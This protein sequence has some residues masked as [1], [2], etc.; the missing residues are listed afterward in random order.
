MANAAVLR[1]TYREVLRHAR[2]FDRVPALRFLMA[3]NRT[4]VR[5]RDREDLSELYKHACFSSILGPSALVYTP[6]T[7]C[8]SMVDLT[9]LLFRHAHRLRSLAS[10]DDAAAAALAAT[11][12]AS[13]DSISNDTPSSPTV[14]RPIYPTTD[15][16]A[17]LG[18]SPLSL[19][20]AGRVALEPFKGLAFDAAR[21]FDCALFFMRCFNYITPLVKLFVDSQG[22]LPRATSSSSS[23]SHII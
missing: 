19:P 16:S 23:P 15:V 3:R 14:L 6:I 22:T 8:Q 7:G 20:G 9:R 12:T 10:A 5:Q 1:V 13:A 18:R 17:V 4:D 21:W 2:A 11:A